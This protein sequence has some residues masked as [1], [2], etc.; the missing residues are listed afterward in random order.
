MGLKLNGDFVASANASIRIDRDLFTS[1]QTLNFEEEL[2]PA[3]VE[4]IGSSR[5]VGRT[6]GAYKTTGDFEMPVQ[7]MTYLRKVLA[8]RHARGAYALVNFDILLQ[9]NNLV[10]PIVKVVAR[11]C[12]LTKQSD[13]VVKGS[14][15]PS[16]SKSPL[17]IMWFERDGLKMTG[18]DVGILFTL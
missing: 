7:E 13:G 6:N 1:I 2:A 4:A 5:P 8:R 10:D 17:S 15:D 12:R 14:P 9:Y 11:K 16:L 18:A 3:M